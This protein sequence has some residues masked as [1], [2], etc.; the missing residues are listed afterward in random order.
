M[1]LDE[2]ESIDIT[3]CININLPNLK[4]IYSKMEFYDI[5][6]ATYDAVKKEVN[7]TPSRAIHYC[8]WI[9]TRVPSYCNGKDHDIL[10][11]IC[12]DTK[13]RCPQ[14]CN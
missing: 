3:D 10:N 11:D 5:L 7:D 2:S 4:E 9:N 13:S 12:G 6:R 14:P 8:T 1:Q